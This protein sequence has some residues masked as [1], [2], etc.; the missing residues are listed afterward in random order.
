MATIDGTPQTPDSRPSCG[1]LVLDGRGTIVKCSEAALELFGGAS[2]DIEGGQI[3]AFVTNLIS[4]DASP[5][6]NARRVEYL[7]KA[8]DWRR[9][10]AVD[11]HGRHFP[12]EIAMSRMAAEG[13]PLLVLNLRVPP[14]A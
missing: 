14:L 1:A 11:L 6:F 7:S 8:G 3:S 9:F 5:S 12:V 4:S 10:Q 2:H 13:Q